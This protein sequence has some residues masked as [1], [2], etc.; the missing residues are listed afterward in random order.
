MRISYSHSGLYLFYFLPLI[1]HRYLGASSFAAGTVLASLL[2]ISASLASSNFRISKRPILVASAVLIISIIISAWPIAFSPYTNIYRTA[3]S[4]VAIF[5]GFWASGII[6]QSA[7]Q[8]A[9]HKAMWIVLLSQLASV[10]VNAIRPFPGRSSLLFNEPSHFGIFIMPLVI[11]YALTQRNTRRVIFMM[12]LFAACLP[13]YHSGIVLVAFLAAG[14]AIFKKQSFNWRI[15]AAAGLAVIPAI[16]FVSEYWNYFAARLQ[17]SSD[18]N[19]TILTLVAAYQRLESIWRDYSIWGIGLQNF[20]YYPIDSPAFDILMRIDG[21]VSI[22]DGA[23]T[24][25]KLGTEYGLWSLF[26][27]FFALMLL[28]RSIFKRDARSALLVAY[29]FALLIELF[30]RG[31]GYFSPTFL[32]GVAMV[33]S[34]S[35]IEKRWG[36][37][38]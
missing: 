2:V 31:V 6:L 22:H 15:W 24:F 1:F 19:A 36:K 16:Y 8:E 17:F 18:S 21:R 32:L 28:L 27:P 23:V 13:L 12:I 26:V 5:F 7:R 14:L 29:C 10:A 35:M 11:F 33:F 25:S 3:A 4:A 38:Q 34:P 30:L 20:G 9:Y 37:V